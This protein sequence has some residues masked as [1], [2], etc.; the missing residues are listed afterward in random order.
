MCHASKLA[1]VGRGCGSS[2]DLGRDRLWCLRLQCR[3]TI[4]DYWDRALK[5]SVLRV[6]TPLS[7]SKHTT[8]V[9]LSPVAP[10]G[11]SCVGTSREARQLV[12]ATRGQYRRHKA[13]SAGSFK[14]M[15]VLTPRS[16][17]TLVAPHRHRRSQERG[18]RCV[19]G[20]HPHRAPCA[21]VPRWWNVVGK[22][23]WGWQSYPL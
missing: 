11:L 20:P 8:G 5:R 19:R 2:D 14:T 13:G 9:A 3:M 17:E 16:G 18:W 4:R 1:C 10:R 15:Q 21:L 7:I 12:G 23:R 6:F 22:L